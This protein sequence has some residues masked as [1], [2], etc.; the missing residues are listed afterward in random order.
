MVKETVARIH[1]TL[2]DLEQVA[3]KY[4]I[5]G[6]GSRGRKILAKFKWSVDFGRIDGLR[7]KVSRRWM[8]VRTPS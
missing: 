2:K 4:E 6:N 5:L 1:V 7:T 3:K 8:R